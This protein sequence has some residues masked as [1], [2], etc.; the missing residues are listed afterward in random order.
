MNQ[1]IKMKIHQHIY[2]TMLILF[3]S[4]SAILGQNS[5]EEVKSKMTKTFSSEKYGLH[6]KLLAKEG[7]GS[8]L[9]DILIKASELVSTAKGCHLYVVSI[10]ML[11]DDEVWVTEIW[12]SREDHENSLKIPE[13]RA[14]ISEAMPILEAQQTKG[15]KL[16]VLGGH[17]VKAIHE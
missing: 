13:V 12:E 2:Y 16:K 6:G 1:K 9:A 15:R 8:E 17:G 4:S 7:K 11:N 5:T 3:L 10:D 14:L